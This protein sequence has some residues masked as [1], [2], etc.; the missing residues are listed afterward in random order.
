[1]RSSHQHLCPLT[2][3]TALLDLIDELL[4]EH[5]LDPQQL[6]FEVTESAAISRTGR[7]QAL[8]ARLQRLGCGFALDDFGTGFGSF[9]HLKHLPYGYIKIDGDF[10]RNLAQQHSDR[11]L[12]EAL[13]SAA[14]GIGKKT[15]AEFVG[16]E[17]TM[18]LLRELGVDYGQGYHLGRPAPMVKPH[19]STE[20]LDRTWSTDTSERNPRGPATTGIDAARSP[21]HAKT[22][23][24]RPIPRAPR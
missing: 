21:H 23:A 3:G 20:R 2:L 13:V 9:V 5:H 18:K 8:R 4:A 11:V 14:R 12:V 17:E 1:M 10:V 15:V 7:G 19:Q 6:I 22:S 16:D 24:A